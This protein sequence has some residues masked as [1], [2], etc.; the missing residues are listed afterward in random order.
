MWFKGKLA[1]SFCN[2]VS[3][4]Y[5]MARSLPFAKNLLICFRTVISF[6]VTFFNSSRTIKNFSIYCSSIPV[7]LMMFNRFTSD[8]SQ[9]TELKVFHKCTHWRYSL[10]RN[11]ELLFVRKVL[12]QSRDLSNLTNTCSK[13]KFFYSYEY[14]S[15]QRFEI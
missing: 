10:G 4:V 7:T 8:P 14:N 3:F 11:E 1:V 6:L 13:L 15:W 12:E 2:F 9:K 5:V